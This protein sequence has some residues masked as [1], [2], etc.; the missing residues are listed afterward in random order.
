MAWWVGGSQSW[1]RIP[2]PSLQS[3]PKVR[4]QQ[5]DLI[6]GL[7]RKQQKEPLI[8]ESDRDGA[9][10]DII[11]GEGLTRPIL[12]SVCPVLSSSPSPTP[13]WGSD[14]LTAS[15]LLFSVCFS[16]SFL[17]PL[18]PCNP[19]CSRR[20]PSRPALA[21]GHPGSSVRPAWERRYPSSPQVPR[22]PGLWSQLLS[23]ALGALGGW[24]LSPAA[25]AP[26]PC[27]L[28]CVWGVW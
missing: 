23:T 5:M 26:R 12:P 14:C 1:S 22:W 3:P 18:L 28:V 15:L 7:K 25:P 27:M 24:G 19:Q 2:F 11:T 4:R 16:S 9:I 10:E 21:S 20:C 17:S 6:S 13:P 8:Y